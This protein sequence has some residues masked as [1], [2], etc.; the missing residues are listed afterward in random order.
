M[1]VL[2]FSDIHIHPHKNSL[3]RL[4]DCLNALEWVFKTAKEYSINEI[5]FLGDLFQD[6]QKIQTLCYQKTFEI[7]EKYTENIRLHL[8]L[9]NHDMFFLDK[10]DVS[11]ILPLRALTNV[12]IILSPCTKNIQGHNVDFLPFTLNPLNKIGNLNSKVLFGHIAVNGAMIN[13]FHKSSISVEQEGEVEI[14]G[15]EKFEK[16]QKVF[17]GHY[18]CEQK[19]KNIEYVGSTL[20]LNFAEAFQKKHIVIL[21]IDDLS[22]TYIEN[23]SSP[24]HFIIDEENMNNYDLNNAFVT[25][26]P[27]NDDTANLLDIKN[28]IK[29]KSN[30]QSINFAV[31]S[32]NKEKTDQQITEAKNFLFKDKV[33]ILETYVNSVELKG[34]TK[35]KLLEIGK[36]I[37]QKTLVQ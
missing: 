2:L 21:D 13:N 12:E 29:S 16:W 26:R 11:S 28:E 23:N 8:L 32:G 27:K 17:L 9:G 31:S 37:C 5:I 33:E 36:N 24:K 18:H 25:V 30:P 19:I 4:Q 22:T 35:D 20:Q 15:Q 1:S 3:S 34:L 7:I 10:S 6:R 14:V